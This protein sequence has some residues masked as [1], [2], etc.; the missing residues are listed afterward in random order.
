MLNENYMQYEYLFVML[1]FELKYFRYDNYV[2]I[3][4]FFEKKWFDNNNSKLSIR[5]L[6]FKFNYY[7]FIKN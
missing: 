1:K 5:V 4:H 6:I 3:I 7:L 2:K